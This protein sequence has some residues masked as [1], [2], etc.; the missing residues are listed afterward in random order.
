[1]KV[2]AVTLGDPA[3]VGP[4]VLVKALWG[5]DSIRGDLSSDTRIVIFGSGQVLESACSNLGV[6]YDPNILQ[7]EFSRDQLSELNLVDIGA[8]DSITVG[9]A[10]KASGSQALEAIYA[11]VGAAPRLAYRLTVAKGL[12]GREDRIVAADNGQL[13][14][15]LSRINQ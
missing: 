14:K 12:T 8:E 3:G 10:S 6:K 13:L 2:I 15:R 9:E 11:A 7:Q 1:M 4:E 5:E